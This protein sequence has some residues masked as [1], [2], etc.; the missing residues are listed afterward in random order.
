MD[1]AAIVDCRGSIFPLSVDVSVVYRST[2]GKYVRMSIKVKVPILV[3]IERKGPELIPDSRQS[4][5][6]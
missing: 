6:R 2:D 5:C 4:A 1:Y 3:Y